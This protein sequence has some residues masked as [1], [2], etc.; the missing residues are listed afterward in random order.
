MSSVIADPNADNGLGNPSG[1]A[2]AQWLTTATREGE[3]QWAARVKEIV[4][5][6]RPGCD[7]IAGAW[8]EYPDNWGGG[9]TGRVVHEIIGCRTCGYSG[10]NQADQS[11]Q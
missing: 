11:Q 2:S 10:P 5:C 3:K 9:G 1:N 6:P 8:V 7:G 4:P